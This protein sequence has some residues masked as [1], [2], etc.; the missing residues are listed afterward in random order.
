MNSFNKHE[1][2]AIVLNRNNVDTDQ[3]LPK[4]FMKK[5]NRTGF[6]Q[7]LFYDWRY[8]VDGTDNPDFELNS[9]DSKG[10]TI[11]VSGDNFG[12]GSSREHAV[13]A[14]ADYGFQVV[15][16]TSFSD[17]FYMNCFKN[18]ILPVIVT[19]PHL[20]GLIEKF[21]EKKGSKICINLEKQTITIS[22]FQIQFEIENHHKQSLTMGYDPID[23]TLQYQESILGF[24]EKQRL[25]L[26]WL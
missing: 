8:R 15:I 21:K 24:E 9:Q 13:W 23:E 16:A 5:T 22:Q 2:T 4:Q 7:Y 26:P 10:A 17:I 6:G 20:S 18:G 14:I 25:Q 12:C 19:P 11:L 3:I 1:G